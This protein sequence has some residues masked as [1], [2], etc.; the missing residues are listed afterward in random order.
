MKKQNK[1]DTNHALEKSLPRQIFPI[2]IHS[3]HGFRGVLPKSVKS[4][5]GSYIRIYIN[6]DEVE[7]RVNT[8]VVNWI[9]IWELHFNVGEDGLLFL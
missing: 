6:D 2:R 1:S 7:I 3:Q 5:P 9:Y 8:N 4:V